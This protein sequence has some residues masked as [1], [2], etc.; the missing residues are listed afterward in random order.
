MVPKISVIIPVYGVESYIERCA[1]ALFEQTQNGIEF[2]FINDCSPD[3]SM[4]ILSRVLCEYPTV[5]VRIIDFDHNGGVSKAR[6]AGIS[7]ASGEYIGFCDSDDYVSRDMYQKLYDTAVANDA[8]IVACGFY[9]IEEGQKKEVAFSW[10]CD[11]SDLIFSFEH[12]GGVYGAL[13]NKV[14]KREFFN[15][16]NF[17]LGDDLSMWED[18]CLLI[19]LRLKSKKTVFIKDCL[20][21]YNVNPNGI[22]SRFS[23]KKISDSIEAVKRLERF[24]VENGYSRMAD[25]LI[26]NLKINAKEVLLQFPEKK[27]LV[28]WRNIFPEVNRIVWKYKKWNALLKTRAYLASVL[29]L[30]LALFVVKYAR[31]PR[32]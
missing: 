22:T 24:F 8:D 15:L 4:E 17:R 2:I 16:N 21:N 11:S 14:F 25:N 10:D 18:S 3:K 32:Y 5:N 30:K 26:F 27:K 20:Y 19:P 12:F 13:W 7:M 9:A 28:A 6:E 23:T 31:K 29:P 1:R